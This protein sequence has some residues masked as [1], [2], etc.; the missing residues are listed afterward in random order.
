MQESHLEHKPMLIDEYKVAVR[1]YHRPNLTNG[2]NIMQNSGL[3]VSNA[4]QLYLM[5]PSASMEV[6]YMN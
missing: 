4:L 5:L 3:K 1:F 6:R 2:T